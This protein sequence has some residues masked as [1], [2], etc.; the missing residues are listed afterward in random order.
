VTGIL[1][2]LSVGLSGRYRLDRELGRGGMATVF[3]GLDLKHQRPVA[4][5]VL[6]PDLSSG[7]G[8]E[9]FLH[10]ISIAARLNHP[11]ILPLHDSGEVDGLLY[12]VMPYVPGET[13]HQRLEREGPLPIDE[14]IR[15]V[16]EIADALTHAHQN[17]VIHRDI[18]PEN[19][20]LSSGHAMVADFG[21]ARAVDAAGGKRLTATGLAIGTP[22]YMSPELA[23]GD[24]QVDAR[25][26]IYSLGCVA[27]AMLA[28]APPFTGANARAVMVRHAVDAPPPLRTIR[29]TVSRAVES[30]VERALA[31]TPA[32]RYP[33][34]QAFADALRQANTTGAEPALRGWGSQRWLVPRSRTTVAAGVLIT[35]AAISLLGWR[36]FF[37]GSES[38]ITSLAVLPFTNLSGDSAQEYFV[39]G[40]QDALITE[41]AQ[42]HALRVISRTSTLRFR[43]TSK[44][45]SEIANELGV[46]AIVEASM[47]RVGDSM[48]VQVQVIRTRPRERSLWAQ[49]YDRDAR[50]AL[51]TQSDV[52]QEIA[53]QIGIAVTPG[54]Q[55]H[56]AAHEV[57]PLAYEDYLRGQHVLETKSG[58]AGLTEAMTFF[59]SAVRQDPRLAKAHLAIAG[60]WSQRAYL[61]L[62]PAPEAFRKAEPAVRRALELDSSSAASRLVLA[63]IR[64]WQW[65]WDGA[66]REY[67]RALALDANNPEVLLRYT[68]FQIAQGRPVSMTR[69][70]KALEIDPLNSDRNFVYGAILDFQG[71]FREAEEQYR[72]A[73]RLAPGLTG[74]HWNLHSVLHSQRRFDESLSEVRQYFKALGD[75]AIVGALDSGFAAAGYRAALRR[76]ADLFAQRSR[77]GFVRAYMP[78]ALYARA[79]DTE[80]AIDW[81]EKAVR[82][83][84]PN[85]RNLRV[86]PIAAEFRDH[87][88]YKALLRTMGL[89]STS[90][91]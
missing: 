15:I 34:V 85:V 53:Q 33:T 86:V 46:D 24:R 72:T 78:A 18:K 21:I 17:G 48:R 75:T 51:D 61:G 57:N 64:E 74:A 9:R 3:L 62:V 44:P 32:D 45:A 23:G 31:K 59:E 22:A 47:L 20:F 30:A 41:L 89:D 71:R 10:E 5:K 26:D 28:G 1:E 54:A 69:A 19:I 73:L 43:N 38:R 36:S 35:L 6:D 50:L 84:D 42:I 79:G 29:P 87:P 55:A 81:L 82:D 40:M 39:A 77:T 13:L 12:Y 8:P 7:L 27:Y 37:A 56:S 58:P 60:M 63:N 67:E 11:L 76:A 90:S 88:R 70:I 91:L 4:I 49:R 16:R 2:R 66:R 52:A 14:A 83:R 80:R 25:S 68:R 65:D